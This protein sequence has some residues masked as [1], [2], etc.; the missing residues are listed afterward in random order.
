MKTRAVSMVLLMIASALAGCTAGDPDGDGDMG[1]DSELLDQLIQENLQDFI[2]NTTVTVVNNH[3][4]NDSNEVTNYINSSSGD[5]TLRIMTGAIEGYSLA[6]NIS[7][8]NNYVL[9]VRGD[10]Y[11][12]EWDDDWNGSSSTENG[13]HSWNNGSLNG[14]NIC[15]RLGSLEVGIISSWFTHRGEQNW[16]SI[17]VADAGEASSKFIDGSCDAIVG[18][19]GDLE[20][21][22]AQLDNDGSMN[23]VEIW[24]TAP[25]GQFGELYAV[26]SRIDFTLE[27]E[28][29]TDLSI[30]YLYAEISVEGNCVEN[31]TGEDLPL[32]ETFTLTHDSLYN[33]YSECEIPDYGLI[34]ENE[35]YFMLPGLECTLTMSLHAYIEFNKNNYDYVWSDWAYYIAWAEKEVNMED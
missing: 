22:K 9:L 6:S 31:C 14:I 32:Y 35:A 10:R 28:Y 18:L 34:S 19:Q 21:K 1:I 13:N 15:V 7:S 27:Q 23:G 17:P 16:T 26:E 12:A 25:M 20:L 5:S 8:E 4:S 11:S 30:H 33:L 24:I 2:N 29:G 3:Y